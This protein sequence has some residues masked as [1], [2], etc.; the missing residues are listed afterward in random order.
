VQLDGTVR[1]PLEALVVSV[2]GMADRGG[3]SRN[4]TGQR[5]FDVMLRLSGV[6]TDVEPGR[7]A[8]IRIEGAP[9]TDVLS[10]PRQAVF[11]RGGTPTVFV[12]EGVRFTATS[13]TVVARTQSRVVVDGIPEG[14]AV[15][16]V[17]PERASDGPAPA[18]TARPAPASGG[19]A[20]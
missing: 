12:R 3:S 10:L 4:P 1:P 14:T 5:E 17:D 7:T 8:R 20:R 2:S 11:D 16:L 6:V 15:A 9:L 13:V 18:A 19:A